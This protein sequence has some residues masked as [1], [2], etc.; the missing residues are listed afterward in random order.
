[1]WYIRPCNCR[2]PQSLASVSEA[3]VTCW[4]HVRSMGIAEHGRLMPSPT[5]VFMF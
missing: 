4:H 2:A 3:R 1:M 5:E